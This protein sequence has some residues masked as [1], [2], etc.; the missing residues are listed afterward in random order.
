MVSTYG[1]TPIGLG[2][3]SGTAWYRLVQSHCIMPMREQPKTLPN[4]RMGIFEDE[5]LP[6]PRTFG[7]LV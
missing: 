6:A 3:K 2:V 1:R 5:A 7:I 4:T